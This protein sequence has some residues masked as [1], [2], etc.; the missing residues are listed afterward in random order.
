MGGE[1]PNHSKLSVL[2]LLP[3]NSSH[4]IAASQPRSAD[5]SVGSNST[6]TLGFNGSKYNSLEIDKN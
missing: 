2:I 4:F 3:L 6:L 1:G 5:H